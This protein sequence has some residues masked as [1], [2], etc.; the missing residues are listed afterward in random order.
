MFKKTKASSTQSWSRQNG[1][2]SIKK[3]L[4][5]SRLETKESL[6]A[7]ILRLLNPFFVRVFV[8]LYIGM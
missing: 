6:R 7:R 5:S 1:K 2:S 8:F 3:I 4:L